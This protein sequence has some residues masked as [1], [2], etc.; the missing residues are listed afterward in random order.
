MGFTVLDTQTMKPFIV[1]KMTFKGHSRSEAML[2]HLDFRWDRKSKWHRLS[3]KESWNDLEVQSR[4]L[5]Q[6]NSTGYISLSISGM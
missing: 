2:D 5:E 3:D 1:S 6:H 4:S